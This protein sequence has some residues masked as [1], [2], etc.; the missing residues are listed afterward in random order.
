MS[1][2]QLIEAVKSGGLES[3]QQLIDS[4]ADVNQQDEHG[5][6]PLNWAAGRG[7]LEIVKLLVDRGAEIFKTGRDQRTPY[8]IALAA[9][10]VEVV[11]FL[12][13]AEDEFEGE[14]PT[15]P[16]RKYCK[17]YH[18]RDLRQFAGWSEDRINWKRQSTDSASNDER[19][20]PGASEVL[21]D[22]DIIFV[23]QDYTVTQSM[24][25]NENVIFNRVG[26]DWQEFCHSILSF[27]VPDDLDLIGTINSSGDSAAAGAL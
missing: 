11:K 27:K 5:W 4:G 9:A 10:R 19:D 6:T 12:R 1:D 26:P 17:A 2:T 23:H 20:Q 21:N 7:D 18:L 24:W 8:M 3:V 15:R 16:E 25:H 14:K 13:K 22:D